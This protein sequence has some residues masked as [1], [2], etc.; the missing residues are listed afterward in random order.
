PLRRPDRHTTGSLVVRSSMLL[1]TS[2]GRVD[3]RRAGGVQQP[4]GGV[5]ELLIAREWRAHQLGGQ[6]LYF[7]VVGIGTS[8]Q[9]LEALPSERPGG[10]LDVDG[11]E[12]EPPQQLGHVSSRPPCV[13]RYAV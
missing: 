13:H 1:T 11:G 12:P 8:S 4:P 5:R 10:D 2:A 9:D 3:D 7:V 6:Q